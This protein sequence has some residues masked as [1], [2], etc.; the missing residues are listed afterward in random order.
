[1]DDFFSY[2]Y[3]PLYFTIDHPSLL[4]MSSCCTQL[5]SS[6]KSV[7]DDPSYWISRLKE[8]G[9]THFNGSD[10]QSI[11]KFI[12]LNME[13]YKEEEIANDERSKGVK[14][15]SNYF[16]RRKCSVIY[17][18]CMKS[19]IDVLEF[20]YLN[21]EKMFC[22]ADDRVLHWMCDNYKPH[23]LISLLEQFSIDGEKS[24]SCG[25]IQR[26]LIRF[27]CP[28]TEARDKFF[29]SRTP[30]PNSIFAYTLEKIK[31]DIGAF[32]LFS[33][34]PKDVLRRMTGNI[35]FRDEDIE[36]VIETMTKKIELLKLFSEV[37]YTEMIKCNSFIIMGYLPLTDPEPLIVLGAK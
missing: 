9:Y 21:G 34:N 3:T 7:F 16:K 23:D 8:L 6:S 5:N 32:E 24:N 27:V 18:A 11:Y 15:L 17:K 20:L 1:M 2:P 12:C 28:D 31:N 29:I 14:A 10:F 22:D 37:N 19:R 33:K 25:L 13:E 30:S 36:M 4:I 26:I 35:P